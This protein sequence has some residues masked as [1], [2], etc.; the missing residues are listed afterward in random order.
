VNNDAGQCTAVVN[1]TTP[2]PTDNCPGASV[3]CVPA[4]GSAFPI[5]PTTVTCTATDA[6]GLT[7]TCSFTVTV[8]DAEAPS[9]SCPANVAVGNDAGQCTAVVNYTTPTPTDNCPGAT[10]VCAPAP[11]TAFAI[12]VTTVTCTATDASGLTGTCT[13]TVT[14]ADTQPPAV[15]CPADVTANVDAGQC[16]AAVTYA[17]PAA[18]DNCPGAGATV[19]SPAPGSAFPIGTTTVTC[20]A[21]DAAGLT[22]TCSFTVTVADVQAPTIACPADVTV[23]NTPGQC[24]A[25]VTYPAPTVSDNCPGV[26][27]VCVPAAGSVFPIGTTAVTC[28]AT[29]PAGNSVSCGFNVTVADTQPPTITCPANIMVGEDPPLSGSAVVTYPAPTFADNCPGATV[30]CV[31]ASGSSFPLGATTVTCTAT[32]AVGTAASCSFTVT[33]TQACTIACPADVSVPNTPGQCG[34]TVNYPPPV[35]TGACTVTCLPASGSFFPIGPTTVNCVTSAGPSCSFTVTVTDTEPPALACPAGVTQPTA[36]GQCAAVVNY[37]VSMTDNCAGGSLVCVPAPG[38]I[39][40]VGTTTVTCTATDAAGNTA[41][42]GFAVTVVDAEAPGL[43][44]PA[45]VSVVG[46]PGPSGMLEAVVTYEVPAPTDNCPGAAVSCVPASGSTFLEG[47]T[48]VTCTATDASG[49]TSTCTFTV[50]VGPEFDV[51]LAGDGT[52]D[53]FGIVTDRASASYGLWRYTVAATGEVFTGYAEYVADTGRGLVAYD[54]DD[55]ESTMEAQAT[56]GP[57]GTAT[58]TVV[59]RATGRRFVLRD[60]NTANTPCQ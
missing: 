17:V 56:F 46:A 4:A 29:D 23:P 52:G 36:P 55:P 12:G 31:P 35:T 53:T 59:D 33:V 40:G 18:T 38:S 5:G 20:T 6:G 27:P 57:R 28:T 1:Y 22:G 25:T 3:V 9:V 32:D 51:C 41:T 8:T 60:L 54:R 45:D 14:V 39:F 42:C 48:P 50:T 7:G 49:N 26:A 15:T 21:T 44:C 37:P 2:T 47:V 30:A 19:C 43:T 16:T 10:V 24:G 11:G 34:A 58:V 13:F